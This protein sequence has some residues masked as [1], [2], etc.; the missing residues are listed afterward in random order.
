MKSILILFVSLIILSSCSYKGDITNKGASLDA[1]ENS[2]EHNNIHPEDFDGIFT[3]HPDSMSIEQK[4]I[5]SKLLT[6]MKENVKIKDGLIYST[7]TQEDFEIQNISESYY[8]LLQEGLDDLNRAIQ[9]DG[10]DAQK[11]YDDMMKEFPL[12]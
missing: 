12:N 5:Q 7:A 8:Y 3:T 6:L 4:E 10:L 9:N 11:I 2:N 1:K